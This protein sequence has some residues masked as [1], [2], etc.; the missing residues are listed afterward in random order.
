MLLIEFAGLPNSG[1]SFFRGKLK[2]YF[3]NK[4][5]QVYNYK[6]LILFYAYNYQSLKIPNFP[7]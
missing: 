6:E 3:E 2:Q 4:N 5:F 1:K 7:N